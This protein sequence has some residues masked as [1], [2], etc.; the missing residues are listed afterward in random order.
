MPT[1]AA[2]GIQ[3]A[4]DTQGDPK[5]EAVLLIAGL[6][7][8]LISWPDAFCKGLTSE[9]LRVIR[10]DNRD[11]GLST[12]MEQFGKPNLQM[13]FFKSLFHMPLFSGY[14]LYDMAK[15]GVCLL[16]A[17]EIEKAHIVGAS[18]GGMIAQIIAGRH[19]ERVLSL[20]SIMSTSGRPGLP[21]PSMAAG[22]AMFSRPKNPRDIN[23]VIDH[24]VELFRLLGGTRYPVPEAELRRR[25]EQSV[26]RNVCVSGTA[27][28]MMAVTS[29]GDQVALLRTIKVPTLVIHGTDDPL[30]PLACG[31][32][33][34]HCVRG[35][36]LKIIEGMGHD[37]PPA[38]DGLLSGMIA[39]HCKAGGEPEV[40]SA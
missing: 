3:L 20:T 15:D 25:V 40:R 17:L 24:N 33:V 27:R 29:S 38:L 35:S 9:G 6:G 12:K 4:Y 31:R 30:V 16:D 37:F 8:Q 18:M 10:F 2:N 39:E 1:T 19:P 7:L 23:S 26:R 5:G 32:D 34:A 13:A 11:S 28:Q 21:G 36:T 14:T 22:H